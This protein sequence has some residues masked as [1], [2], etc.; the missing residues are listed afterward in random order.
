MFLTSDFTPAAR[1]AFCWFKKIGIAIAANTPIITM[2]TISSMRG[3]AFFVSAFPYEVCE[4]IHYIYINRQKRGGQGWSA[5]WLTLSVSDLG[6]G[7]VLPAG[8]VALK[9]FYACWSRFLCC[10]CIGFFKFPCA[11]LRL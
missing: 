3:E 10:F 6:I 5:G 2:T 8:R 4:G 11:C 9:A 7:A 1:D